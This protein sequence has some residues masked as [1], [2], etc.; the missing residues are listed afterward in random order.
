MRPLSLLEAASGIS[1]LGS[2]L[3]V[4]VP[5]F[6]KNLHASRLV[7]PVDGL[8]R[9]AGAATALAARNPAESAYPDTVPLTPEHVPR[10]TPVTDPPGTWDAPTWRLLGFSFTVPHSYS[11]GF[12]SHDAPGKAA[13]HAVAHGDLDGDG[14][15]ST[16]EITG[17]SADGAEPVIHPLESQREV[18]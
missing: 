8:N 16:F 17:E 18:E 14:L 5:A 15:V 13:F 1:L 2:I 3:A 4:S 10:G 7:E 11:F 12:D 9:I 6:V